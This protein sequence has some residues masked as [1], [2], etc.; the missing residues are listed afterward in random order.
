MTDDPDVAAIGRLSAVP[1]ILRVIG[2][3]TGLRLTLIARV[4]EGMWKACAVEDRMS[5]GLLPGGLLDVATT[6][7]ADVRD[8]K[9]PIVIDC[10]SQDPVYC[11]H[12]TPKLYGIESYISVPIFLLDGSYFG[13]VCA[14]DSVPAKLKDSAAL[15]TLQLYAE[16]IALQLDAEQRQEVTR[17]AL[18]D[19]QQTAVLREQFIALLGHDMRTPLGAVVSGTELL[20]RRGLPER[21][22]KVVSRMQGSVTRL[23]RLV[24]HVLDF[25]RGR[26]GGGIPLALV[27]ID[28]LADVFHQIVQEARAVNPGRTISFTSLS[29]QPFRGDP[30]RLGQLLANLLGNALQHG[31]SDAS[32]D[33]TL[34]RTDQALVL[35]VSNKGEAIPESVM[36]RL[37][38]PFFRGG[39]GE[40]SAGLGLGLYIVS[41]I[42]RSHGG[43]I[44]VH[45]SPAEG[46]TFVCSFPLPAA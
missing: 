26:L 28:D 36:A 38:H 40:P 10:A 11:N 32:V 45:S 8:T 37:F 22:L 27:P 13:N 42:V 2:Q 14:L 33:V 34:S 23:V 6:L 41:E 21:D 30:D 46:T 31:S 24:D 19:A 12:H 25:A 3:A 1:T 4:T 15:A 9:R 18:L 44:D 16:L 5:F 7:C 39:S 35:Q 29:R 17:A 20:S 43:T